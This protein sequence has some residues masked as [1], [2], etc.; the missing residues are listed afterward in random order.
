MRIIDKLSSGNYIYLATRLY[1]YS[2]KIQTSYLELAI[3]EVLYKYLDKKT[4]YVFIPFR[5]T[6][7]NTV[8]SPKKS[9]IIYN[10]D[11][12]RLSSGKISMLISF[13][14][15]L[16]KDDGIAYEI[17]YLFGQGAFIILISTDFIWYRLSNGT[18]YIF[19]PIIDYMIFDYIHN[20]IIENISEDFLCNLVLSEHKTLSL[21]QDKFEKII[22]KNM[23]LTENENNVN[24]NKRKKIYIDFGGNKYEFQ[25]EMT[26]KLQMLIDE[27]NGEVYV[28]KRYEKCCD[29]SVQ[30]Q[31][32]QLKNSEVFLFLGDSEEI[33]PG[34]SALT[35]LSNYMK[36][37]IWMYCTDNTMILGE[38][39]QKMRKNFMI[40]LSCD[41]IL[42]NWNDICKE[43][44]MYYL[45]EMYDNKC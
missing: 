40:E 25:R 24:I 4:K 45:G 35:G 9:E 3:K 13:Y 37:K 21:F 6:N 7:E 39:Q 8:N 17:G 31:I 11:M 12:K 44:T 2:E 22:T 30:Y 36:K 32:E 34:S 18:E 14:N 23:Y 28:N 1:D 33:N 15:D 19:E 41:K 43:I 27:L 20:H 5:D 16:S 29:D 38:G 42:N 26:K 10:L